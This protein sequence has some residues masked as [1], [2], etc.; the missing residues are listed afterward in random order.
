MMAPPPSGGTD[1]ASGD[2]AAEGGASV[3]ANA[4]LSADDA[5][6]EGGGDDGGAVVDDG[7]CGNSAYGPALFGQ[8]GGDDDCKYDVSWTSTPICENQPV[9]FTVTATS[10]VDHTPLVGANVLPDVVLNCDHVIPN[11]P[12]EPTPVLAPGEYKVGPIVFDRPGNW[13]VRF[14]FYETCYDFWP[15]SPHGHAA[16]WV[17]VP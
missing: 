10:R 6:V 13:V 17:T 12:L 9:Y 8:S 3:D 16:F 7:T 2:D 5:A 11:I 1:A 15:D 14:H 4:V